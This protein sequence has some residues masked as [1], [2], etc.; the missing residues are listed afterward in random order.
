MASGA[1]AHLTYSA[2]YEGWILTTSARL[3][4]QIVGCKAWGTTVTSL[5]GPN[6][7]TTV[8][9]AETVYT[10]GSEF[11]LAT[12]VYTVNVPGI[13]TVACNFYFENVEYP[14]H[15]FVLVNGAMVAET[16]ANTR[17]RVLAVTTS[18]PCAV[19]DKISIRVKHGYPGTM[20]LS[21]AIV[22]TK[23]PFA[24]SIVLGGTI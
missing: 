18:V 7:E 1:L 9:F 10:S 12:S 14:S 4:S 2:D 15:I 11:N 17:G 24:L 5:P 6:I 13:Y 19:G 3:A 23:F 16:A 22:A 21:P 8:L 20:T